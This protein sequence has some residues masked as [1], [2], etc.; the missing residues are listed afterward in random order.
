MHTEIQH[1]I[2]IF[3]HFADNLPPLTPDSV[4][5]EISHA[6]DHLENDSSVTTE[7]AEEIVIAFGKKIWA[8]WK[9]FEEMTAMY[10][11]KLGEKFLLSKLSR[12]LKA[13]YQDFLNQGGD[14]SDVYSGRPA[15][16]FDDVERVE[17]SHALIEID[18]DIR[19]YVT[20]VVMTTERNKYQ[21]LIVDFQTILEDIEKRLNALRQ[22][23]EDEQ[24]HPQLA[25]EIRM[26]VKN[27][28]YGLCLLAEHTRYD[29][30][31][32]SEGHFVGRRDD[33][34]RHRSRHG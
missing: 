21:N 8:Y 3:K 11:G 4:R 27:F 32:R 18:S 30:V 19:N 13:K 10:S 7:S 26:Q 6:L 17:L 5:E 14:F 24:E 16:F 1:T 28:E 29:D 25:K 9:A 2:Y 22:V 20:Q 23:A 34:T 33:L 12:S 31:L 15:L